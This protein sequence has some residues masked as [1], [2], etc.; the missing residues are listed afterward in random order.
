MRYDACIV[1][2]WMPLHR[3]AYCDVC[4]QDASVRLMETG[5]TLT[6]ET[7]FCTRHACGHHAAPTRSTE[8]RPHGLD[9]RHV[10]S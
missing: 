8:E 1:R 9:G 10:S 5:P 7:Y 4:G 3:E 6:I 2:T